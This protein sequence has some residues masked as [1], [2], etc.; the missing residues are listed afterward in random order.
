MGA[1]ATLAAQPANLAA[2]C[3]DCGEPVLNRFTT[4]QRPVVLDAE[5]VAGGL[6][7]LD[8]H[9]RAERRSLVLLY[10]EARAD[11]EQ[12]GYNPHEC[13]PRSWYDRD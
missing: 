10:L 1:T 13:R 7:R 4:A 8:R 6:Y 5:P 11:A 9:G 3:T 12:L 2:S